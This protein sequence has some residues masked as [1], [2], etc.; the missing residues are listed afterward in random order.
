MNNE[1]DL[2]KA[3]IDW[4]NA[5]D[6]EIDEDDVCPAFVPPLLWQATC[7]PGKYFVRLKED[8]AT[9]YS[10]M[11]ADINGEFAT[12]HLILESG[13]KSIYDIRISSIFIAGEHNA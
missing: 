2:E 9:L 5:P 10:F 11:L 12:L 3:L 1:I 7:S 4:D 6:G 13:A 8:P